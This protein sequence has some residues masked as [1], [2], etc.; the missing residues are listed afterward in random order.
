MCPATNSQEAIRLMVEGLMYFLINHTTKTVIAILLICGSSLFVVF[1]YMKSEKVSVQELTSMKPIGKNI[2]FEFMPQAI[3]QD[4]AHDKDRSD[5]ARMIKL[6]EEVMKKASIQREA[7]AIIINGEY[8]GDYDPAFQIWKLKDHSALVVYD[9][10]TKR[11][12]KVDIPS[13]KSLK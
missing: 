10:N 7:D 6:R 9:K 8:Y 4:V 12:F 3:A 2:Q 11:I 1:D 5:I 13:L